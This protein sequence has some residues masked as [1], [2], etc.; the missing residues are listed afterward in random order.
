MGMKLSAVGVWADCA[1]RNCAMLQGD[2]LGRLLGQSNHGSVSRSSPPSSN[3]PPEPSISSPG[4]TRDTPT[5]QA[6]NPLSALFANIKVSNGGAP[7]A[8]T[9]PPHMRP[10]SSS[11]AAAGYS[12]ALLTPSF[13]RQ[14][15]NPAE[16]PQGTAS[17]PSHPDS[18][19]LHQVFARAAS[20]STPKTDPSD[21]SLQSQL[22][23]STVPAASN[24]GREKIRKALTE[25]AKSDAFLDMIVEQ[26]QSK[27]V[28]L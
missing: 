12:P 26:L 25:L 2:L 11:T 17:E 10:A 16:P 14:H 5:G 13:F 7:M 24:A 18:N 4:Q 28:Q 1:R 3:T 20:K 21:D 27:G 19:S 6:Q 22:F 8:Q 9:P 15:S 23:P